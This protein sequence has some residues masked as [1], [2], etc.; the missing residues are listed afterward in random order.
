MKILFVS[1]FPHYPEF[2]DGSTIRVKNLLIELAKIGEVDFFYINHDVAT[3]EV[4]SLPPGVK[5]HQFCL[6]RWEALICKLSAGNYWLTGIGGAIGEAL[7]DKCYDEV[8]IEGQ[9]AMTAISAE[10][11]KTA[12]VNMI[13]PLSKVF[14]NQWQSGKSSLGPLYKSF[15]NLLVE[16]IYGGKAG[17]V[18][19]VARSDSEYL[20]R[21]IRR[22]MP[23]S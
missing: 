6:G 21:V 23:T 18:S 10:L 13:D 2:R 3:Y 14:F 20:S 16:A 19:C 22:H 9:N 7:G 15:V 8:I 17:K 1:R 12:S 11:L 4:S 5:F